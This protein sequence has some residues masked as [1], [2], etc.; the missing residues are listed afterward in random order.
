MLLRLPRPELPV[1]P[2]PAAEALGHTIRR[3]V[4]LGLHARV[5]EVARSLALVFEADA[6]ALAPVERRGL[7]GAERGLEDGLAAV[8]RRAQEVQ[9][10]RLAHRPVAQSQVESARVGARR[11][12][13]EAVGALAVLVAE[14]LPRLVRQ[15]EVREVERV[16]D[17]AQRDDAEA[18]E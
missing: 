3:D 8:E 11:G 15:G 2:R 10:V 18:V 17:E 14:A 16:S 6:R 4:A 7:R 5:G 13:E 12:V 1:H 9:A